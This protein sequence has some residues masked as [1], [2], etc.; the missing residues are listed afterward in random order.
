MYE[1]L[2]RLFR[3]LGPDPVVQVMGTTNLNLQDESSPQVH[4]AVWG[5]LHYCHER[6]SSTCTR[7]FEAPMLTDRLIASRSLRSINRSESCEIADSLAA[8][9]LGGGNHH[10]RAIGWHPS[11]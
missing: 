1:E 7:L 4:A 2:A 5:A 8:L 6:M 9:M 11:E 10:V 3:M